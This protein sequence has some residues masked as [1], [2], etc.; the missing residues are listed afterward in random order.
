V[1]TDRESAAAWDSAVATGPNLAGNFG[2]VDPLNPM[3]LR[4]PPRV[5]LTKGALSWAA[6]FGLG[7]TLN[8]S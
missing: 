1:T 3:T 7:S 5:K 8:E 2:L 6:A 4:G